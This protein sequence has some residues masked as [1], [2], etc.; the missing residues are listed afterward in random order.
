M[1]NRV[2][3]RERT[4]VLLECSD[5]PRCS[6]GDGASYGDNHLA[7]PAVPVDDDDNNGTTN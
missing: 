5:E 4:R 1:H 6:S 2:S 7:A 3:K